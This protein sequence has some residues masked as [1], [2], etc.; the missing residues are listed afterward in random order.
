MGYNKP[1]FMT[2][3]ESPSSINPPKEAPAV[4]IEWNGQRYT[5]T[6]DVKGLSLAQIQDLFRR[7][8]GMRVT[9]AFTYGRNPEH[10]GKPI[11]EIIFDPLKDP[12]TMLVL[13]EDESISIRG[14]NRAI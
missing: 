12:I 2:N 11:G 6:G 4:V 13:P 1:I 8:S 9:C 3:K 10:K 7:L 5:L 14:V